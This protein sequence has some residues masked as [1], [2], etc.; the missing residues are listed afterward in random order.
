MTSPPATYIEFG[1]ALC[2]ALGLNDEYVTKVSFTVE[3]GDVV[4]VGVERL[5]RTDEVDDL[6]KV[7][8]D[9]ELVR[10]EEG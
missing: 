2:E 9:Y 8:A 1:S 10:R 3:V 5:L 7:L 6:V 4:R